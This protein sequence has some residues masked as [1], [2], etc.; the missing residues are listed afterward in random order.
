VRK[1][2]LGISS[3]EAALEN[4]SEKGPLENFELGSAAGV[5]RMKKCLLRISSE[6]VPFE[7]D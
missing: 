4:S 5:F 3:E 2:S 7:S 6:E 1:R